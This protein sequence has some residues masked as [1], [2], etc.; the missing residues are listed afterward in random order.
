MR[1]KRKKYHIHFTGHGIGGAL[2]TL[3]AFDLTKNNIIRRTRNIYY[4]AIL[5]ISKSGMKRISTMKAVQD[6]FKRIRIAYMNIKGS[7]GMR[8]LHVFKNIV[9]SI[10]NNIK[11]S[12][13]IKLR[14]V[15]GSI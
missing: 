7:I 2:A 15:R 3:S 5:N 9:M 11:K 1:T 13:K 6:I 8:I 4:N 12:V 10:K 14:S